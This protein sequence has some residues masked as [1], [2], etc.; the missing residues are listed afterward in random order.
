MSPSPPI[1]VRSNFSGY[2]AILAAASF[3]ATSGI[4]IK[5]IMNHSQASAI[6]L[7]FWRDLATFLVLFFLNISFCGGN[8]G[9]KR[10]D[11]PWL[12]ALGVSLGLFHVGLNFGVFLN[13]AAVT[14]IQQAAMPA[15]VLVVERIIWH[16]SLTRDKIISIILIFSGTVLMSGLTALGEANV[17]TGGV[18]AGFCIP[19][20]YGAWS[21]LGKKM[22]RNYGA[23]PILT[24]AFGV[25]AVVLL[26]L[27]F[28]EVH[29]WPVPGNTWLWFV[30]LVGLSTVGG[31]LIYIFGL[32]RLSAGVVTI[33]AM[34]EIVFSA[35]LAYIFLDEKL[36]FIETIGALVIV[37]GIL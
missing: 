12:A 31:F 29:P 34:S 11:W 37:A 5:L 1:P 19:A 21:L 10:S 25:A 9:V 20:L 33:V 23:L 4:F 3:W 27:Q 32:G 28:N 17:S 2:L 15:M 14:T 6:V 18:L 26:P 16:E 22:R 35:I 24:Y 30:G 36:T 8:P 13:G 7:A